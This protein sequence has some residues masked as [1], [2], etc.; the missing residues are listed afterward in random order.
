[1]DM[2]KYFSEKNI[3]EALQNTLCG[4]DHERLQ[5]LA[6]KGTFGENEAYKIAQWTAFGIEKAME[7][8]MFTLTGTDHVF[9]NGERL[10]AE[11][12]D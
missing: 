3:M 4:A 7:E 5:A 12:D 11:N 8:F 2:N 10:Q 9:T 6:I 1:M